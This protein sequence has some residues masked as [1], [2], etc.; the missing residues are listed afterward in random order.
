MMSERFLEIQ[1]LGM[2]FRGAEGDLEVLTGHQFFPGQ[3][4]VPLRPGSIWQR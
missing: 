1:D 2:T 4:G 3:A